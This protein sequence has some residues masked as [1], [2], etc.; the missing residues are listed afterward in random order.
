M[1]FRHRAVWCIVLLIGCFRSVQ[2]ASMP[3]GVTFLNLVKKQEDSL[4]RAWHNQLKD[5]TPEQQEE[6]C[7]RILTRL[8]GLYNKT[9]PTIEQ[10]NICCDQVWSGNPHDSH[11]CVVCS[12]LLGAGVLVEDKKILERYF[13]EVVTLMNEYYRS[14]MFFMFKYPELTISICDVHKTLQPDCSE[15]GYCKLL[16]GSIVSQALYDGV[17]TAVQGIEMQKIGPILYKALRISEHRFKIRNLML[18]CFKGREFK[19]QWELPIASVIDAIHLIIAKNNDEVQET[20]LLAIE[21]LSQ[22]LD[23]D[24]SHQEVQAVLRNIIQVKNVELLDYSHEDVLKLSAHWL[25]PLDYYTQEL[26]HT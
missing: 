26:F 2:F 18:A 13:N 4:F 19:Q 8:P 12:I 3:S 16:D 5:Y 10:F 25:K 7:T 6:E 22:S 21:E 11:E 20:F 23:I 9:V 24:V 17:H 14:M 1:E 15:E